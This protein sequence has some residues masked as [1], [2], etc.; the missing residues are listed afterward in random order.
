MSLLLGF[1]FILGA[2]RIAKHAQASFSLTPVCS[3][4]FLA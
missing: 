1:G 4:D 3:V 2:T